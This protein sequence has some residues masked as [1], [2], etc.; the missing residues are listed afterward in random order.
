MTNIQKLATLKTL[1]EEEE[2]R[3]DPSQGKLEERIKIM[4]KLKG[5]TTSEIHKE[6]TALNKKS[7]SEL[8]KPVST[9]LL[10]DAI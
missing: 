9:D 7:L 3:L 10:N 6:K 1:T 5:E 2:K 8:I 4:Q